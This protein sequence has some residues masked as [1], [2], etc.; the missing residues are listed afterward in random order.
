MRR[1]SQSGIM[2]NKMATTTRGAGVPD[3]LA[4]AGFTVTEA[5]DATSMHLH[6]RV[7]A[8]EECLTPANS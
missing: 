2:W 3:V 7:K 5:G 1:Q 4:L 6:L 8:Q